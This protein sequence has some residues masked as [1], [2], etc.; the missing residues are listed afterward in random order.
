MY[1]GSNRDTFFFFGFFTK[2][3]LHDYMIASH[4]LSNIVPF[5]QLFNSVGLFLFKKKKQKRIVGLL[6]SS[7][8]SKLLYILIF[9][10]RKFES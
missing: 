5:C 3:V 6:V 7:N 10:L 4:Y 1:L 8:I 2:N 9:K